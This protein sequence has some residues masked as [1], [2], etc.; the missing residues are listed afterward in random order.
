MS[1]NTYS[2]VFIAFF[3]LH[4]TVEITLALLQMK[5]LR[6]C[7]KKV[8]KHLKGKVSLETI[9]KAVVYNL[10]KLRFGLL[11]R[12]LEM[13]PL[14]FMLLYGFSM[15][16]AWCHGH[17]LGPVL[18]GLLF[19]GGLS[20]AGG[21]LSLPGDLYFTF[22]IEQRHGFNKQTLSA[23]FKD[24]IKETLIGALLGGALLSMVLYLMTSTQY[25]W[26]L[27]F[28]VVMAF[29]L[30]MMWI[31][32]LV[33]MPI[34]N[35]FEPVQGELADAVARL[36]TDVGFPLKG[37]VSMDG[38]KRSSHS[39]AFIIGFKGARRIVLYDT[40]I[41]KLSV[42]K[43][44]GVLA[45]ELGHY[46][47]GH[48]KK[49]LAM[50]MVLGLGGFALLYWMSMQEAMYA[51]LGFGRMSAHGALVVFSLLFAETTFPFGLLSRV[52]SRR[53]EYAADRFAVNAVQNGHDL[54]DALV[55]LTKQNL[56]SPGS[57]KWYRGYYNSHPS[58]RE[59]LK[60]I[61]AEVDAQNYPPRNDRETE[62]ETVIS[63]SE[64]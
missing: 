9:Q 38:S 59:R 12:I 61:D 35:T 47:L 58:L 20:I 10:E 55:T 13:I 41:E 16:D 4:N 36:A 42:P 43:L 30:L 49:R 15:F 34:F 31:Y 33:I 1:F 29:Q 50:A 53:D 27:A 25:W 62:S 28:A 8:P 22:G 54:K 23:W 60:A 39:N 26:V 64:S 18:T 51:G 45:H 63:G 5:H 48:I 57:H 6:G 14:W 19:I 2:Y 3:V 21:I 24:K 17:S 40:L 56:S 7:G 44:V 46:K 32:P 11:I 52:L 37:V